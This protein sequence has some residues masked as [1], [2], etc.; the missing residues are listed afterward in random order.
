MIEVHGGGN[1]EDRQ[2]D[3]G[4]QPDRRM[5]RQSKSFSAV[6]TIR[7][8][9]ENVASVM[10]QPAGHK[11]LYSNALVFLIWLFFTMCLLMTTSLVYLLS[12]RD[13]SRQRYLLA[14]S[15]RLAITA[16]GVLAYGIAAR[17]AIDYAIQHQRYF[18]PLDYEALRAAA[19]PIFAQTPHLNAMNFAFNDRSESISMR[20]LFDVTPVGD[21]P[22]SGVLMQSDA[23]DC[24][25]KLGLVGCLA[26]EEA[27]LQP[28][29]EA[30]LAMQESAY[31]WMMPPEFVLASTSVNASCNLGGR[32]LFGDAQDA[33]MVFWTPAYALVFRSVFPGTYGSLSIIGRVVLDVGFLRSRGDFLEDG[34]RLGE[35]G[36]AL[37]CDVDGTLIA[38]ANL[39][40]QVR[41][42]ASA[43]L[44]FLKVWE[45]VDAEWS[46]DLQQAWPE[47]PTGGVKEHVS[48][49]FGFVCKQL[50]ARGLDNFFVLLVTD[51]TPF[52]DNTLTDLGVF[53]VTWAWCPYPFLV[54]VWGVYAY[55]ERKNRPLLR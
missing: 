10:R 6:N 20:R 33:D 25:I 45:V 28:W 19:E 1:A 36:A 49:R 9:S 7:T 27:I 52:N 38:A 47:L 34:G 15:D 50:P 30:G 21:G 18:D 41:V 43:S 31:E 4:Q 8:V 42:L 14:T 23:S 13:Q 2:P 17:D 29:Y 16:S 5:S 51:R 3:G 22:Q 39:G 48:G 26:A 24:R 11:V 37:I 12:T 44:Q 46:D 32:C 40:S 35:N 54:I 55:V 53:A